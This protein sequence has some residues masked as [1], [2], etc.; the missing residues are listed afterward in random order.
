M[1]LMKMMKT[2]IPKKDKIQ[3]LYDTYVDSTT[4]KK[5]KLYSLMETLTEL[6]T[7]E[8]SAE[9]YLP[10][11]LNVMKEINATDAEL[12][13]LMEII[14][15]NEDDDMSLEDYE[16]NMGDDMQSDQ[17]SDFESVRKNLNFET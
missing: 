15:K 5:S 17:T 1:T 9:V 2:K 3:Y 13:K 14:Y 4:V 8:T 16:T 11:I 7:D 10:K 12:L 6:M